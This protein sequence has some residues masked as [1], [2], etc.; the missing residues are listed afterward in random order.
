[1]TI[2]VADEQFFGIGSL[3]PIGW[4]LKEKRKL[5]NAASFREGAEF[6]L[7]DKLITRERRENG[8][9]GILI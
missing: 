7:P 5:I 4:I 2:L 6:L 1:M 9:P 3:A 8:G